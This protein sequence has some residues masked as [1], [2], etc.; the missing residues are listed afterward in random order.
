[1]VTQISHDFQAGQPQYDVTLTEVGQSLGL[2]AA[3]LARQLRGRYYGIEVSRQLQGGDE[4][5]ILVRGQAQERTQKHAF[6]SALVK[7]PAGTFVPLRQVAR[8]ERTRAF[9]KI[10]RRNGNRVVDVDADVQPRSRTNEVLAEVD[11]SLMP[12]LKA[13]FPGISKDLSGRQRADYESMVSLMW[14]FP[15]AMIMMFALLAIPFGSYRLALLILGMTLPFGFMGAVVG[16]IIMGYPATIPGLL[17]FVALVGV[18]VNDAIVLIDFAERGRAQGRT[19]KEAIRGAAIQRFR[20]IFLT[21]LTTCVGL[22]PMIL[23][24]SRQARFLIPMAV[25]LVF[26]LM[27]ATIAVL[28]MLPG[29]YLLT[30]TE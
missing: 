19:V 10:E 21:T 25:S 11:R 29:A 18:L 22:A 7:T 24:S 12:Q 30:S 16:H 15:L 6:E 27:F 3:S 2:S 17:G 23:E 13:A 14:S 1:M 9:T 28:L 8:V 26:G 20:P 4:V 5:T